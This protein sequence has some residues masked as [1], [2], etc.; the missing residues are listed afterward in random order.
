MPDIAGAMAAIEQRL[1]DN[2]TTTR[3][4]YANTTPDQPW[5]PVDETTGNTTPWVLVEVVNTTSGDGPR[6]CGE[7]GNQ[8]WLYIGLINVHVFVPLNFGIAIPRSYASQIG[9]IFRNAAFYND[10]PGYQVR[11][12]SP[13]IDGGD[14]GSDD[15]TWFRVTATIPFEYYH[16]G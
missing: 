9:D 16:R 13:R 14:S 7:P 3:I 2:W 5:P 1:A 11:T 15:G 10:T 6:A 8:F 12:I 4:A